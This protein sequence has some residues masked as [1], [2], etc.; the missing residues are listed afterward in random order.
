MAEDSMNDPLPLR[1]QQ[2]A[3][4]RQQAE[5]QQAE[6]IHNYEVN[7]RYTEEQLRRREEFVKQQYGDRLPLIIEQRCDI[8]DEQLKAIAAQ[9]LAKNIA[10]YTGTLESRDLT[11]LA[12]RSLNQAYQ[13]EEQQR[14][15][16]Q[17]TTQQPEQ[18]QNEQLRL[19]PEPRQGGYYA[20]LRETH[21]VV[22]DELTSD[23][24]V[25]PKHSNL[26]NERDDRSRLG[27]YADL[28]ATHQILDVELRQRDESTARQTAEAERTTSGDTARSATELAEPKGEQSD[29]K[30]E[31]DDRARAQECTRACV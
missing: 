17:A 26:E 2:S 18:H 23:G 14:Q 25:L 16:Q 5:R 31:T 27:R 29:S 20:E 1:P 24:A 10:T 8:Q 22:G 28:D 21:R 15:L 4:L 30:R 7:R 6:L 13:F 12:Q 3:R 9:Y 19:Q 11:E